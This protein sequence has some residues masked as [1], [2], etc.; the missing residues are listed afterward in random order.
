MINKKHLNMMEPGSLII[1]TSR[2]G[3]INEKDL[4]N[5]LVSGHIS[6]AAIDAFDQEPYSGPLKDLEQC[7]LTAHMGSMSVDCRSRM[8]IEAT[9]E[10]I[11][12]FQGVPLEREVPESEY[13]IQREGL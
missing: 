11:R 3:I 9:E 8:E 12:F 2:G 1:N 4:Y 7:I 13:D 5:C 10:V 6:G